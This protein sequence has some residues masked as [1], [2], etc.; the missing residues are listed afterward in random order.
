MTLAAA[1]T[2]ILAADMIAIRAAHAKLAAKSGAAF[3]AKAD[4]EARQDWDAVEKADKAM[5]RYD[6]AET[7][8]YCAIADADRLANRD[9]WMR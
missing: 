6:G 9:F 7:A 3:D 4:A 8:L 1:R 2:L 5:N